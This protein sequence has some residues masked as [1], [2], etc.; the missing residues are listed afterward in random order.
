M[1][2]GLSESQRILKENARKFF[3]NECPMAEVRR[4]METGDAFDPGL[5]R[6]MAEQGF[7]GIIF[8]ERHGGLGLGKVEMAVLLEEMGWALVPGPYFSSVLLAG[9]V[10]DAAGSEAQKQQYLAPIAEG[11]ARATL[12]VLE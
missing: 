9:A 7:T 8:P 10:I 6:K 5:Y 2:F 12:A 4:I 11:R 1:N 3:V